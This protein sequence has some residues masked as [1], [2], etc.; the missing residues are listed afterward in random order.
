M[1]VEKDNRPA[2]DPATLAGVTD[3]MVDA[4]FAPLP[5]GEEWTPL[6]GL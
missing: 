4:L 1:I 3:A 5:A 2:W 6:P